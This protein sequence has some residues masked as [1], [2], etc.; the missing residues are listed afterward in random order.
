M[1]AK[2][3]SNFDIYQTISVDQ[4]G[5]TKLAINTRTNQKVT[6]RMFKDKSQTEDLELLQ[7]KHPYI[8]E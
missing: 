4:F 2:K 6:L 5:K 3:I 7:L 8:L 1:S